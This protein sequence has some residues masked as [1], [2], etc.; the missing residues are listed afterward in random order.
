MGKFS[1]DK[2]AREERAIVNFHKERGVDAKR[3]PLSGAAAGFK[4]DVMIGGLTAEAKL[5]KTGFKQ[6][7]DWLSGDD[8]P[9]ILTIRVDGKE[10][11]YI[12]RE[13]IWIKLLVWA[14]IAK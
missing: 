7:Y 4:H 11:I 14:G 10:R 6:I 3:V 9:D 2:G 12:M 1:R 5:R 8:Q 13:S